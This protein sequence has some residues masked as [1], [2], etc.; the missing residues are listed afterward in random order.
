MLK[1]SSKNNENLQPIMAT[2]LKDEHWLKN[3]EQTNEAH[4]CASLSF[5]RNHLQKKTLFLMIM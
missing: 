5:P 3:E 1:R 2:P 4:R